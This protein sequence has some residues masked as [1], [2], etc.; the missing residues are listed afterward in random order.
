[1][2]NLNRGDVVKFYDGGLILEGKVQSVGAEVKIA[3]DG[4]NFTVAP[5]AVVE[6]LQVSPETTENVKSYL[7]E[8]FADA[9]GFEDYANQLTERLTD[10]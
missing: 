9:Y 4:G 2:P 7:S 5:E 3:S 6:I 8:Y 1:V 10:A